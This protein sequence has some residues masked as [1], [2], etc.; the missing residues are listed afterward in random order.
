MLTALLQA[1]PR[2]AAR[3]E[4]SQNWLMIRLLDV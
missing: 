1:V 4:P 2:Q 3:N